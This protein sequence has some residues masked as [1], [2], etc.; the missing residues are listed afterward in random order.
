MTAD[1][2]FLPGSTSQ[3]GAKAFADAVDLSK[4]LAPS[5]GGDELGWLAHYRVLK[6][7]GCGGMGLVFLA[8]DT[9]LMRQVALKV[10][11]PEYSHYQEARERFQR[12]AC[13][14]ASVKND[15]IVTIYQ[16][17]Q[18][19]EVPYL[20]MELLHG[21]SLQARLEG[22]QP[23]PIA[24]VLRMG[25]EIAAGLAAAHAQG[26]IHRDIKPANIWL[27][28]P[29]GRVK[30]LDFGLA[31][32][33]GT[34]P[35]ITQA[36][37]IIGTPE[38]MAPEQAHG[39]PANARSDLFSL[40][41]VLYTMCTGQKPFRGSS[42]MAVLAALAQ[43]DP[44][45]LRELAPSVPPALDK[46]VMRL[47][48]KDP[49]WR[50]ASAVAVQ[51]ELE[52][53][54]EEWAPPTRK[55]I[56]GP[57]KKSTG[58]L[59]VAASVASILVVVCAAGIGMVAYNAEQKNEPE[60]VKE[61]EPSPPLPPPAP[62]LH[63]L[64]V[65]TKPEKA[66]VYLNGKKQAQTT[67]LELELPPG[68]HN[69]RVKLPGYE[70]QQESFAITAEKAPELLTFNLVAA[71]VAPT[72]TR[73]LHIQT[74]PQGVAI[75]V[76]DEAKPR[77]LSNGVFEMPVGAFRLRLVQAGFEPH[78]RTI[79]PGQKEVEVTLQP[80]AVALRQLWIETRPPGATV[81]IDNQKQDQ[82][83]NGSFAVTK[84]KHEVRL[85]LES[86]PDKTLM[87]EASQT[88]LEV[89]LEKT[90]PAILEAA[91]LKQIQEEVAETLRLGA[92]GDAKSGA[93]YLG[94]LAGTRAKAWRDAADRGSVEAMWLLGRCLCDELGMPRNEADGI[95]WYRKAAELGYPVAQNSIGVLYSHGGAVLKD[96]I[97][98]VRWYRK[99][100]EQG[101]ASAQ[102]NLG[103]A[104]KHARG[105][106]KNE[107]EAFRWFSRAAEQ[108]HA[109]A[110]NNLGLA[111][112]Y[113]NGVAKDEVEAVRWFR[114]AAEKG[115]AGAQ[116]SLGVSYEHGRG[117]EKDPVEAVRWY[118]KAAEQGNAVAQN[119][120]GLAYEVGRGVAKDE[121]VAIQ[122][123]RKAAD[124]GFARALRNLGLAYELGRGVKK[125]EIEA[126]RW[127]RKAADQGSPEA[128]QKLGVMY[129]IGRGVDKN[130]VEAVRW[131]RKAADQG[132]AAAQ[133]NLGVA[134]ENGRGVDK[135]L[136]Q[137]IY[138]YRKAIE[139]GSVEAKKNLK[140]L[141]S[142]KPAP[143]IQGM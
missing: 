129:T 34:D 114:K 85:S 110:Q 4:V 29:S 41:T 77:G 115:L 6:V 117:V 134:Y 68:I 131:Y 104:Y 127:Y 118:R 57:R 42:V 43:C 93:K 3:S 63:K 100:A 119:N 11:L 22:T 66:A 122:W 1:K 86:F 79:A 81:T 107:A 35:G 44:K 121:V 90:P 80:V 75:Y 132:I 69:V 55:Q 53:I 101:Y 89:T 125:D 13:L 36:G 133:N 46:L 65:Q 135:D 25:I 10:I 140:N 15:H 67:P 5:A 87:V 40:G 28:A 74:T 50:P 7:L 52:A 19:R 70:A 27:E 76:N 72:A 61:E 91:L 62:T 9:H 24:D 124:Q 112:E 78:V 106:D 73:D 136:T 51:R 111:Y 137:A 20:A 47:L 139:G 109:V 94:A 120:L 18:D 84:G 82:K 128:Q 64:S 98:A 99:A 96:E 56:Y 130:D 143:A 102:N 2:T 88:K 108:G 39:E 37:K 30:L 8:E 31:R 16:V 45:P 33:A 38:Y 12:E 126:A 17:G 97:E 59:L 71:K 48:S 105:V 58:W 26:L 32:P 21:E 60:L 123:F 113:G 23:V 138:W 141:E 142:R 49:A 92:K 103:L 95:H 54:A 14:C 116:N 83:T